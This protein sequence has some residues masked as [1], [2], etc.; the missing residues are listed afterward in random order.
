[1]STVARARNFGL[2]LVVGIVLGATV[3]GTFAR[4]LGE[5]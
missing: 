5:G 2:S 1:M 3:L 4:L